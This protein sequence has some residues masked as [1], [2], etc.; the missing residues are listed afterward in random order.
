MVDAYGSGHVVT[1]SVLNDLVTVG[2][3]AARANFGQMTTVTGGGANFQ[4]VPMDGLLGMAYQALSAVGSPTVFEFLVQGGQVADIFSMC[5]GGNK[6]ELTLGGYEK[7]LADDSIVYVP[8]KQALYYTIASSGFFINGKPVSSYSGDSYT[9]AEMDT[10]IDSGS[11]DMFLPVGVFQNIYDAFHEMCHKHNLFGVCDVD[12]S[13]SLFAGNCYAMSSDDMKKFPDVTLMAQPG[14]IPLVVSPKSYLKSVK[15]NGRVYY[16]L[17][18]TPV[19]PYGPPSLLLGDTFMRA[20]LTVFDRANNRLGF[21]NVSSSCPGMSYTPKGSNKMPP[22]FWLAVAG[23]VCCVLVLGA[24]VGGCL[25]AVWK[26][27]R[28]HHHHHHSTEREY[29]AI[30]P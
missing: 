10:I 20:F 24:A 17:G 8:I 11:S 13:D 30:N 14:N 5:M 1:S 27:L 18:M 9:Y 26:G 7:S 19:E 29:V 12:D 23:G 4:F 15:S 16:C 22:L 21:A 2:P 6:G 28:S 3:V 25:F